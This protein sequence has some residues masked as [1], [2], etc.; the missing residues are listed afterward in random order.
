MGRGS[1]TDNCFEKLS[2]FTLICF[3]IG[4][5]V[6]SHETD[7]LQWKRNLFEKHVELTGLPQILQN[8]VQDKWKKLE[9]ELNFMP[10]NLHGLSLKEG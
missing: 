10:W 4:G 6:A 1:L 7:C 5:L 3:I 2:F 9:T 8:Q